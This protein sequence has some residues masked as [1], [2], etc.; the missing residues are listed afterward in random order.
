MREKRRETIDSSLYCYSTFYFDLFYYIILSLNIFIYIYIYTFFFHRF[1]PFLLFSSEMITPPPFYLGQNSGAQRGNN[2]PIPNAHENYS[3]ERG[4]TAEG[5]TS[6]MPSAYNFSPPGTFAPAGVGAAGGQQN[7]YPTTTAAPFGNFAPQSASGTAQPPMSNYPSTG[8]AA[9]SNT[10]QN[11]NLPFNPINS[12]AAGASRMPLNH[13]LVSNNNLSTFPMQ[14]PQPRQYLQ[15]QGGGYNAENSQSPPAAN[16]GGAQGSYPYQGF[17]SQPQQQQQQQ[18]YQSLP[19]QQNQPPQ[20]PIPQQVPQNSFQ[21]PAA[22]PS[23]SPGWRHQDPSN[24]LSLA[25]LATGGYS[26]A[27]SGALTGAPPSHQVSTPLSFSKV[28][29]DGGAREGFATASQPQNFASTSLS[30]IPGAAAAPPEL[31][32]IHR[33]PLGTELEHPE[34]PHLLPQHLMEDF[35]RQPRKSQ[36]S[37]TLSNLRTVRPSS[38]VIPGTKAVSDLIPLPVGIVVSPMADGNNL[39]LAT[40][41]QCK[42]MVRCRSCG[43]YVNPYTPFLDQGYQFQC[44]CCRI[45]CN[46][47]S[48]YYSSLNPQT[49][50]RMDRE[51]RPEL[52]CC[53]VDLQAT[54]EFLVTAPRRQVLLLL[55]DC[56]HAAVSCGLLSSMCAG[57][58]RAL[59]TLKVEE[60]LHMGII[61]YDTSVHFFRVVDEEAQMVSAPDIVNDVSRVMDNFHL[62]GVELPCPVGELVIPVKEGYRALQDV[63]KKLPAM[64]SVESEPGCAFGPALNAMMVL[65]SNSGGKVIAGISSNP[66]QGEGSVKSRFDFVKLSNQPKEYTVCQAGIEW[67]KSRALSCSSMSISVDLMVGTAAVTEMGSVY[68]V[69]RFTGGHVY[70][71][72]E[73]NKRG[74]AQTVERCLTRFLASDAIMRVRATTGVSISSYYGHFHVAEVDLLTLPVV[75]EDMAYAVELSV[76]PSL[77]GKFAYVQFSIVY[78]NRNRERRIR[79][80]TVQLRIGESLTSVINSMD[81][82]GLAGI[83]FR[84]YVDRAMNTPFATIQKEI[85]KVIGMTLRNV[86]VQLNLQG[87]PRS[88]ADINV[89]A[90][91]KYLPQIV[92]A[93][94]RFGAIGGS[95]QNQPVPPSVRLANMALILTSRPEAMVGSMMGWTYTLYSPAVPIEE[96]PCFTYSSI[97]RFSDNVVQLTHAGSSLIVWVGHKVNEQVIEGLHLQQPR[98]ADE[99]PGTASEDL[100][101]VFQRMTELEKYLQEVTKSCCV[102]ALEE[103]PE[104]NG[105]YQAE[106][107][108]FMQ[109]SNCFPLLPYKSYLELLW[110]ESVPKLDKK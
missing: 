76:S 2:L 21:A 41:P 107:Q 82:L 95:I 73:T 11:A 104:G 84:S 68:P 79:V 58:L 10:Y 110:S 81:C 89:P 39:P 33:I 91:I 86:Q 106:L 55:L 50:L 1:T 66:I 56:S 14:S 77:K 63:L 96:L 4:G 93:F 74:C 100:S 78:T 43:A 44:V 101:G 18:Q 59:E 75:D 69:A 94:F 42:Q 103:T 8:T 108:R 5:S 37:L 52:C 16:G 62:A 60:Q 98:R 23:S 90:S 109:E 20:Q 53:S 92:S 35:Q 67:Y 105:I 72:K 7:A 71:M 28:K 32:R 57:G 24:G 64:F 36:S 40:F 25:P 45:K 49:G 22:S 6:Y 102:A 15:P 54:P 31:L 3:E 12:N 97:S 13:S 17:S 48:P 27:N 99:L 9:T 30:R 83:L 87:V 80:H 65:L 46:V 61:A 29:N 38:T 47:P 34:I 85:N 19:Q 51:Q 88:Q 26:Q 70:H